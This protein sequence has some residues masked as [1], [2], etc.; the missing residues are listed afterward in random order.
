MSAEFAFL[1]T[2]ERPLDAFD[3]PAEYD[4]NDNCSQQL[5]PKDKAW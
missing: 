1:H 3:D 2:A 5:S 4:E